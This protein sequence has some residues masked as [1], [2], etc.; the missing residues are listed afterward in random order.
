MIECF[1]P[2]RKSHAWQD[3]PDAAAAAA[4]QSARQHCRAQRA[5]VTPPKGN[6]AGAKEGPKEGVKE[7]PFPEGLGKASREGL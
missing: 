3:L 2:W 1:F 5:Q 4:A 6:A 7:G